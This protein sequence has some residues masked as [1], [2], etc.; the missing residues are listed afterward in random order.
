MDNYWKTQYYR[1]NALLK[2]VWATSL[3]KSLFILYLIYLLT[4]GI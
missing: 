4:K 3:L 2:I 1:V